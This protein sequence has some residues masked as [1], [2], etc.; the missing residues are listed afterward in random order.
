VSERAPTCATCRHWAPILATH[1]FVGVCGHPE[2]PNH[3]STDRKDTCA[4]H[5]A[6]KAEEYL[7]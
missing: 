5:E 1:G 2:R 6:P 3:R 4:L 7:R